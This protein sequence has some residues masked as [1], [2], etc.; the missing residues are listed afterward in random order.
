MVEFYINYL[1]LLFCFV[2]FCSLS[3]N[4]E[5]NVSW[6]KL[7][8]TVLQMPTADNLESSPTS[9][10]LIE[11]MKTSLSLVTPFQSMMF[12][13]KQVILAAVVM[14]ALSLRPEPEKALLVRV[15]KPLRP[16]IQMVV[17]L[18]VAVALLFRTS[19]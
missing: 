5:R 19:K 12:Q 10:L 11:L 2:F 15:E 14:I 13:E 1:L 9:S 6:I 7:F 4:K 16:M 17:S 8:S 18:A 3:V